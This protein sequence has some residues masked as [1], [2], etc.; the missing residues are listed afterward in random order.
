MRRSE[1]CSRRPGVL[2]IGGG[3]AGQAVCEAVRARDADVPL[4]LVCGEAAPALRP[5]AA[6]GTLLAGEQDVDALRLRP[7]ELVRRTRG[8]TLR[9][10]GA[11]DRLDPEAGA[12]RARRRQRALHFDHAVL[13]TGSRPARAAVR[14]DAN[15]AGRPRF[16]DPA[17]CEAI[18]R[19]GGRRRGSAAVSSAAACSGSRRRTGSRGAA[20]AVTV[21]HLI[22]RLMERQLDAAAAALLRAGDGG[23]RRRG[24]LEHADRGDPRATGD[25]ASAACGS[26][27]ASDA[28]RATLVVVAIGITAAR[29]ARPRGRP[30]VRA[31][32]RR[33]RRACATSHRACSPSASARSTAASSRDRRPDP[34]PGRGRGRHGLGGDGSARYAGSIPTREAQGDGGR[35]RHDRR[36][37]RATRAVVVELTRRTGTYR[38]LVTD[39]GG[40]GRSARSCSATPAAPSCSLDAVQ[41]RPRDRRPAR[42]AGRGERRRRA[43]ELPDT[44]QVCNCNGVCKGEIVERDP[45]RAA[46]AR[47]QEVVSVD[48][49]RLGLRVAASRSSPSCC[50]SSAAGAAEEPAYLCPCSAQTREAAR[51]ASCASDDLDVG[52]A[53]SR[54]PAAPGRDC[55]ACKPGLALPG[56]E[57]RQAGRFREERHARFINDRVHANIQNDGTFSRRA[58]DP[59]RR[60][61][62]GRAAA[63][64]RRR[65]QATRCRW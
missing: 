25:G 7:D 30:G 42:A 51:R 10:G 52:L 36:R 3:I 58:A 8:S 21:V 9:A 62:A 47:P 34:R 28:R 54:Q 19:R 24:P 45:R 29:R 37:P 16:R 11:V 6:L 53:S 39:A 2:V 40:R 23:A 32:H 27:T 46:S 59:R 41:H 5:R 12:A 15:C 14:R 20:C 26:P 18:G 56:L 22:D 17:D 33:R 44:A 38:K 43:A 31:R 35:P 48:P 60:R 61:H 63:D 65:R 55:G 57:E 4:T 1:R 64:R 50:G 13:C 49:R